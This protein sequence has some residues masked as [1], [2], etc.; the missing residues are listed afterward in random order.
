[1]SLATELA[2]HAEESSFCGV[3]MD[4]RR[5]SALE[6]LFSRLGQVSAMPSI[7]QQILELTSR[8]DV[9]F[10]DLRIVI[11]KD[12]ALVASIL[13][14]INSSYYGLAKHISD[15][16]A[17]TY[18][19]GLRELRN[20]ALT[21]FVSKYFSAPFNHGTYQRPQL[22]NHCVTVGTAAK[23]LAK[24]TSRAT[25]EEAYVAG[26]LHDF[27]Y[28]LLEQN[29]RKQFCQLVDEQKFRVPLPELEERI[30]S[31]DHAMLGGYVAQLWN[32]PRPVC[33]AI[34]HHH[35]PLDYRGPNSDL[36]CLVSLANYA[37]NR[38]GNFALGFSNFSLPEGD[39]F[40]QLGLTSHVL[41]DLADELE[42]TM[43]SAT[44]LASA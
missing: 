3:Q 36:V 32:F 43:V 4:E 8:D 21:V 5:R 24:L 44:V 35:K 26:L 34:T 20:L 39:L 31:F 19:L 16:R 15:I 11:Q 6:R 42:A 33:D 27:G 25:P 37:C 14:R 28:I 23:L 41:D 10:E 7:A 12:P 13:K 38:L 1:M 30:F 18:F 29:L 9:P 22:W 2:E 17:A 40:A